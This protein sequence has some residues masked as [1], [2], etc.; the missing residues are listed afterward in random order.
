MT[1]DQPAGATTLYLIRHGATDANER[2]PYILQG[3]GVN[4]GLSA[5]GRAQAAGA[6]EFL[7]SFRLDRIY[8]SRL[9]R[10]IETA[11]AIAGHHGLDVEPIEELAECHVGQWEGLDWD[12]IMARH[13]DEYRAFLENPAECAYLGGESYGD[14]LRRVRPVLQGLL[15]RHAGETIA[16]VAHNV[17]NRVY[18]ADLLG[19]HLCKAKDLKQANACVNM[20]RYENGRT[21]LI[22]MNACFHLPET[23]RH[24]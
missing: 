4:Y 19:L 15:E 2:R 1:Q 11:Q 12:T 14:V 3:R 6:A 8:C 10:S 22:T 5:N 21:S 7:K 9:L 24:W 13:P 20:I 16:V 18:L 17:V 23:L